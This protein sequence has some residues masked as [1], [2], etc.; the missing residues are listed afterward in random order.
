ME[1][2]QW[3]AEPHNLSRAI[4]PG[5]ALHPSCVEN[6]LTW[7]LAE[8][9]YRPVYFKASVPK[10]VF[11]LLESVRGL[12]TTYWKVLGFEYHTKAANKFMV[13]VEA[14]IFQE[15]VFN[16]QLACHRLWTSPIR[17][18]KLELCSI[19]N[20]V[21]Q[22]DGQM[23][24]NTKEEQRSVLLTHAAVLSRGINTLCVPKGSST[25]VASAHSVFPDDGILW[26]GAGFR[27]KFKPF[28]QVCVS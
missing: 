18:H 22:R 11:D 6:A 12:V 5:L 16:V 17:C 20:R 3:R 2:I 19:L 9:K 25:D 8:S 13:A 14:Q 15:M 26:R 7:T 28:F 23:N 21:L 24:G 27:D 4:S 1:H 10:S